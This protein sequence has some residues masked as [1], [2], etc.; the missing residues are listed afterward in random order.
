MS[1]AIA[2]VDVRASAGGFAMSPSNQALSAGSARQPAAM[3]R[4]RRVVKS[5]PC[6][7]AMQ[8]G[9]VEHRAVR[10][11]V[12]REAHALCHRAA[13]AAEFLGSPAGRPQSPAAPP[14]LLERRDGSR[15]V[16]RDGSDAA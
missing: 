7:P 6:A 12:A 10:D 16:Q 13:Q 4:S 5:W 2:D 8:V 9:I 15:G 11:V 3:A 1:T 14:A